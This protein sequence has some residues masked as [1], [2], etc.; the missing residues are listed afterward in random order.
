MHGDECDVEAAS[1]EAEHQKDVRVVSKGLAERFPEGLRLLR[2][3][4]SHVHWRRPDH[5]GKG[6]HHEDKDRKHHKRLMP[7][8]FLEQTD[9]EWREQK[10]P[11]GAGRRAEPE[12]KAA[13]LLW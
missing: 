4:G 9:G 5:E 1:E 10:L 2:R 13:P 12:C 3:T 11:E 6:Q 8:D 7:T